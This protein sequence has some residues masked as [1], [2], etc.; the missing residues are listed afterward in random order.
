MVDALSL[1]DE[2]DGAEEVSTAL[3]SYQD[4]RIGPVV[5]FSRPPNVAWFSGLRCRPIL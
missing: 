2:L 1:A 4:R 3:G 5:L